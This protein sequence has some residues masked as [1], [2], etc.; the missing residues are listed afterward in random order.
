LLCG[1]L[2]LIIKFLKAS[3]FSFLLPDLKQSFNFFL[4]RPRSTTKLRFQVYYDRNTILP[5]LKPPLDDDDWVRSGV[6]EDK[7][8]FEI[9]GCVE[10][11]HVGNLGVQDD[12]KNPKMK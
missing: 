12:V 1:L 4:S 5:S 6:E 8:I 11:K 3:I 9:Y 2:L 10:D 7:V